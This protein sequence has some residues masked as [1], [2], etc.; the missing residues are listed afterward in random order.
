[1][2]ADGNK[3]SFGCVELES[4]AIHQTADAYSH[5]DMGR[6]LRRTRWKHKCQGSDYIDC[7]HRIKK[8]ET[9]L[10]SKENEDLTI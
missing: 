9:S 2:W 3:F 1:M 6:E 5:L 4:L 8:E 7:N 10:T